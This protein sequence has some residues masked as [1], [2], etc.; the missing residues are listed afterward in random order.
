MDDMVLLREYTQRNSE[1]AFETLVARRVNFVYSAA[2]RQVRNV[3]LAGEITQAVFIILA[4]KAGKIPDRT[5]LT[6]WLFKTTRFVALAQIRAAVRRQRHEK[7]VQMQAE[8]QGAVPSA[9][10]EIWEQMAPLLDEALAALGETDRQ[11][12]LLRFFENKSLAEVGNSLGTGEDTARKRVSRALEKLFRFFHQRGIASTTASLARVIPAH[13]VQAAPIILAKSATALAL[14]KGAAA[15]GS[16]LTLIEGAL[17]L[18]AWAKA[19]TAAVAVA[20]VVLATCTTTVVV[21]EV[22]AAQQKAQASRAAE[23]FKTFVVEKQAQA[24]AAAA[25][26]GLQ[27]PSEYEAFFAAAKKGNLQAMERILENLED[28]APLTDVSWQAMIE[29]FLAFY[30]F[31]FWDEKYALAYAHDIIESLPPGSIY[32]PGPLIGRGLIPALQKSEV[33]GEPCFAITLWKLSDESYRTYLRSMYGDKIYIPTEADVEKCFRDYAPNALRRKQQ[34]RLTRFDL[35]QICMLI[36]KV[37]FDK[38]S[39]HEF[40]CEGGPI[41]NGTYSNL[42]PHGLIF[43]ITRQ[44]RPGL[45]DDLITQSHDYWRKQL[46]P[47]IGDWLTD[48]TSIPELAA[49]TER[50]RFKHDFTG[51]TGDRHFIEKNSEGEQI[52]YAYLRTVFGGLYAWHADHATNTVEKER[53]MR[54]A[55]FAYRQAIALWPPVPALQ[56]AN[57]LEKDDRESDAQLIRELRRRTLATF[58]SRMHRAPVRGAPAG[59]SVVEGGMDQWKVTNGVIHGHSV[60]GD[61]LLLSERKYRNVTLSATVGTTNRE[62]SLAI[63][64]QDPANGYFVLFAPDGLRDWPGRIALY[65]RTDWNESV[66]ASYHGRVFSTMGQSVKVSVTAHGPSFEVRLNDVTVLETQDATFDSGYIG[67]RIFGDS[68]SPC[69]ATYSNLTFH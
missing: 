62:A 24:T 54:E 28:S 38:N 56:Y 39:D 48:D 37:I 32:F 23:L 19:K 63:R 5:I 60:D 67:L 69:D 25:A 8:L 41:F 49:W 12:V 61:S 1:A 51:F 44:P 27:L 9:A 14:A 26:E 10:D 18:M 30:S 15:G 2:L 21:E 31:S 6:G 58:V 40:Y 64:F 34:N 59:W 43:K 47:M 22:H 35:A 50:V 20:G 55:D 52:V 17:K 46:Q 11:A 53:L 66:I 7:E 3:D 68:D 57:L 42:E 65:K 16:T 33:N 13:S 29:T 4:Q 36:G 45:S